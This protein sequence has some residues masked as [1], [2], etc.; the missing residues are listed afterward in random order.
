M[1]ISVN[2]LP[3]DS[4]LSD[5]PPHQQ[6]YFPYDFVHWAAN[7]PSAAVGDNAEG[8]ELVA[9]MDDGYESGDTGS[10]GDQGKRPVQ[11][12]AFLGLY[13]A[14]E[15]A[16][17]LG[18]QEYVGVGEALPQCL[19]LGP[20]HAPH[21]RDDLA[22]VPLLDRLEGGQHPDHPVLGAL[23][24]D[25]AIQYYDIGV[26]DRPGP[27]EAH[28]PQSALKPLGIGLVHLTADSPNVETVEVQ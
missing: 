21:Q 20:D 28:L 5:S 1:P 2:G 19:G 11:A 4:H 6:F 12:R 15:I 7:L 24:H 26:I 27:Q 8:T 9:A 22:G 17:L 18:S 25:T 14:N 13:Q 16:V 3:Q 23:P 10:G